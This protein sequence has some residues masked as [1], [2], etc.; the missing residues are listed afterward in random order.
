MKQYF[1]TLGKNL[2]LS[3]TGGK[4]RTTFDIHGTRVYV[5]V[6]VGLK[7]RYI[8]ARKRYEKTEAKLVQQH[9]KQ[10][11]NVIELGGALGIISNVILNQIGPE[12]IHII[13]EPNVDIV[14]IC[15]I[16]SGAAEIIN[17]AIAYNTKTVSMSKTASLLDNRVSKQAKQATDVQIVPAITLSSLVGKLKGKDYI[18]V[19]DIEGSEAQLVY[20]DADAFHNCQKIIMEVHPEFI[21]ENGHKLNDMITELINLGF[22]KVSLEKNVLFMIKSKSIEHA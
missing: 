3:L 19:C 20:Q 1:K 13:V 2:F 11:D 5:P 8:I 15:K 18:L 22:A 16:N 9:L 21:E 12:A 10:G 7:I 6:S 4:E 14:D 17:A